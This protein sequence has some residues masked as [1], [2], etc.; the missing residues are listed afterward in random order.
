MSYDLRDLVYIWNYIGKADILETWKIYNFRGSSLTKWLRN[1][2]LLWGCPHSYTPAP[3][4]TS[5]GRAPWRTT[6]NGP[7]SR[8]VG[9]RQCLGCLR[10]QLCPGL[11]PA[12]GSF[13]QVTLQIG[14]LSSVCLSLS[15]F[16]EDKNRNTSTF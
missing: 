6:S 5:C 10:L 7:R 3:H 2:R 12:A 15:A 16:Q 4:P 13:W 14:D 1:P 11:L 8:A 9:V